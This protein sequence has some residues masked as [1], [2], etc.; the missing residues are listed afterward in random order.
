MPIL[1]WGIADHPDSSA[2]NGG[3]CVQFLVT[4]ETAQCERCQLMGFCDII[5]YYISKYIIT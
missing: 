1:V 2:V 5:A 3:C 4:F